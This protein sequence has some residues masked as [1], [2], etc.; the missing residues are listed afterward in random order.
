M[1]PGI[2]CFQFDLSS[3]G[4]SLRRPVRGGA[5]EQQF[6]ELAL[7]NDSVVLLRYMIDFGG[8]FSVKDTRLAIDDLVLPSHSEPTR[9]FCIVFAVGGRSISSFGVRSQNGTRGSLLFVFR[10]QLKVFWKESSTL[11]GGLFGD[12]GIVPLLMLI[13]RLDRSFLRI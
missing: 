11:L 6:A 4:E 8:E 3:S 1:S 10:V 9:R 7:V 5:E 2:S 13:S 12:F